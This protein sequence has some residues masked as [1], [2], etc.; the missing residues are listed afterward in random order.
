MM[1]KTEMIDCPECGGEGTVESEI[2]VPM[3]FSNPI[4]FLD[5]EIV[6]CENCDGSGQIEADWEDE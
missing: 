4:G 2:W 1:C 3:S 5:T 6:G